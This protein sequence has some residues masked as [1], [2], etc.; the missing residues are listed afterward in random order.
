M[1]DTP[2]LLNR[3]KTKYARILQD[4]LVGIYL[5]GSLVLNSYNENVSDLDYLVIVKKPLTFSVKKEIMQ[6]TVQNLWPLA[7]AKG[8][9][10]HILLLDSVTTYQNPI[11]FELHFSKMH[12][13]SY[14]NNPDKYIK[15]MHGPDPDIIAHLMIVWKA[16]KTLVGPPISDVFVP[17]SETAYWNSILFDISDAKETIQT[18]PMYMILNLCRALAYKKEKII[19]SKLA[20][21]KW[22]LKN[23]P[24]KYGALIKTALKEYTSKQVSDY[25]LAYQNFPLIEFAESILIQL[26]Q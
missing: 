21:G 14:L 11:S 15:K 7:P 2:K 23:H 9:E 12:L 26:Y 6:V 10:F 22:M 24:E 8:L 18:N 3:L 16:G 4:N 1:A 17:I 5:H 13:S 20:G 19:I 25:T